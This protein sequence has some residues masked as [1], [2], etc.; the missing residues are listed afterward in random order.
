MVFRPNKFKIK[1]DRVTTQ[2]IDIT[3]ELSSSFVDEPEM[4][5]I[6]PVSVSVR[7]RKVGHDILVNGIINARVVCS[8]ALC[9][10]S[11]EYELVVDKF[12]AYFPNPSDENIDLTERIRE[13]IIISFPIKA[14]CKKECKGLCGKCGRNLNQGDCECEKGSFNIRF[15]ALDTFIINED[16]EKKNT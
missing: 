2:G 7:A 13:D 6:D 14:V 15:S 4:D 9:L 11:F 8:C 16:K 3:R 10:Q 1:L 12:S 5:F